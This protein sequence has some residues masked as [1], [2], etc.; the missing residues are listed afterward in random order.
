MDY[1]AALLNNLPI[2]EYR[3]LPFWSWNGDLQEDELVKQ[4]KWMKENGFGGYFMHARGGLQTEYLSEKWFS[5]IDAYIKAG[6]ELGMQ[7]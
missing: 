2:D 3:S 1:T 6:K 7:S 4:V 5:C